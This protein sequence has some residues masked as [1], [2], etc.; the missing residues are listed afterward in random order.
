L[1]DLEVESLA[2]AFGFVQ[3]SLFINS[4]KV[5]SL[6]ARSSSRKLDSH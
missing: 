5:N 2:K 6:R 1:F 3:F 4:R